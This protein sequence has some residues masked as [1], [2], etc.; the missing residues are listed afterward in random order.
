[1]KKVKIILT[2]LILLVLIISVIKVYKPNKN[3]VE[4]KTE[5][6]KNSENL[7]EEIRKIPKYGDERTSS[8]IIKKITY[9]ETVNYLVGKAGMSMA[10]IVEVIG[11]EKEDREY[12][13]VE[14]LYKGTPES[15]TKED[16]YLGDNVIVE[17]GAVIEVSG[18]GESAQIENTIFEYVEANKNDDNIYFDTLLFE[19]VT[20]YPTKHMHI[21][22]IGK[23][24][25][26]EW[27]K[28]SNR[29]ILSYD[30]SFSGAM[31]TKYENN[32]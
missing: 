1:M 22:A 25:R 28:K 29:E 10:E 27:D 24:M 20:E 26:K 3:V 8:E 13:K 15:Y 2:I 23:V 16:K 11:E 31:L 21:I 12:R 4:E 6:I 18:T 9:E 17:I 7:V 14:K 19:N 30:G 32:E 5:E